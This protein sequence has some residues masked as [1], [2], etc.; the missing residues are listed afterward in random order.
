VG[1][2]PNEALLNML[3]QAEIEVGSLVTLYSGAGNPD[4]TAQEAARSIQL[5]YTGIEV[6]VLDGGQ[7]H[8]QYLISVE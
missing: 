1:A 8:Y 3:D 6:E 5:R 2:T 7:A 4:M